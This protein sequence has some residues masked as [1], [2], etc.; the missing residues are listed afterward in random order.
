MYLIGV[1]Y[2][3][4][5][6]DEILQEDVGLLQMNSVDDNLYRR[7]N[8]KSCFVMCLS[9][10]F[11]NYSTGTGTMQYIRTSISTFLDYL[12]FVDSYPEVLG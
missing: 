1:L 12:L 2:L 11:A 6:G 3:R 4:D 5:L 10:C 8:N 9:I 7:N